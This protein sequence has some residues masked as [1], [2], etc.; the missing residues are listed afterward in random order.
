MNRKGT[1]ESNHKD[2]PEFVHNFKKTWSPGNLISRVFFWRQEN[3]SKRD[4]R[5]NY[6]EGKMGKDKFMHILTR[7]QGR[8]SQTF[9]LNIEEKMK[10]EIVTMSL[11]CYFGLT[12]LKLLVHEWWDLKRNSINFQD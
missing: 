11:E 4:E 7:E 10:E 9:A 12:T 1:N 3:G 5:S 2:F 6:N 8:Y